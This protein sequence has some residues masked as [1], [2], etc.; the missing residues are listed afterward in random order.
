M[1]TDEGSAP[2]LLVTQMFL[3]IYLSFNYALICASVYEN[4]HVSTGL[5]GGQRGEIPL[6]LE[7]RFPWSQLSWLAWVLGT[8]LMTTT[9]AASALD[10]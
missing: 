5:C 6:E 1:G 3:R 7:W 10:R 2:G 9:R 4:A 8:Y